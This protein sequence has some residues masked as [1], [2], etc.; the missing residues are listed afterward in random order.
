MKNYY[1]ILNISSLASDSAIKK[2]YLK[3]VLKYHPDKNQNSASSAEKFKELSEAYSVLSDYNKKRLYDKKW[4]AFNISDNSKNKDTAFNSKPPPF[5]QKSSFQEPRAKD[6]ASKPNYKTHTPL[7]LDITL[8]LKI[9]LEEAHLG[10][11]KK[12][13]IQIKNNARMEKKTLSV[14]VPPGVQDGAKLK[15]AD[16]GH[17]QKNLKSG[18]LYVKIQ[19]K[20]HPI[21]KPQKTNLLMTL[22]LSVSDAVTGAVVKI[23]TL[24][25]SAQVLV[26]P[27]AHS[28]SLLKLKN[29]GLHARGKTKRGDLILEIRIDIPDQITEEEKK[30]FKKFQISHPLPPAVAHFNIQSRKLALKKAS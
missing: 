28:G 10:V 4:L 6:S 21:F 23:P 25:G 27:G 22:P 16:L 13:D 20:K 9:T 8:A 26:P 12:I 2:A 24:L 18:D 3:L 11:T 15:L 19:I 14:Q 29:M 30:W 7:S 17:K 1:K 5:H